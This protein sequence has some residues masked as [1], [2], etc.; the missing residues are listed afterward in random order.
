MTSQVSRGGTAGEA[1]RP[2]TESSQPRRR[3]WRAAFAFIAAASLLAAGW[4]PWTAPA[5]EFIEVTEVFHASGQLL[6]GAGKAAISQVSPVDRAGYPPWRP[7]ASGQDF[8]LFAR[9]LALRMGDRTLCLI[10]LDLLEIPEALSKEIGGRVRALGASA[11]VVSATHVHS[12]LGG[13]DRNLAAV[14][15]ATGTFDAAQFQEIADA[16][17]RAALA[18]LDSLAPAS[19]GRA[20]RHL[21]GLNV[22]RAEKDGPID[23]RLTVLA[24]NADGG[25]PV[26]TLFTFDAHPTL[27]HRRSPR[28]DA[29]FPGRAAERIEAA[30]GAPAIFFQ[31]AAGDARAVPPSLPEMPPSE[32]PAVFA[33]AEAMAQRLA[34]EVIQARAQTALLPASELAFARARIGLPSAMAPSTVPAAVRPPSDKILGAILMDTA[35][36]SLTRLGGLTIAAI[37]GEPTFFAGRGLS[38]ALTAE[39]APEDAP[40]FMG[41]ADGY[42]GY[43]ESDERRRGGLGESRRALWAP[44]LEKR[45][46]DGLAALD[47]RLKDERGPDASPAP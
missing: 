4:L 12:S 5:P 3:P 13:Y 42:I 39:T 20:S 30:T 21:T 22:N 16:A 40:L 7:T 31:G 10:S 44:G 45:L 27:I 28:T 11:V 41:L 46:A 6:A 18:S 14:F 2:L 33:R 1:D 35:E 36:L 37:P 43:I 29:D 9:A 15:A 19:L 34:Q 47:R 32:A 23:D 25:L 24:F 17:A 8:P 38:D 26:A